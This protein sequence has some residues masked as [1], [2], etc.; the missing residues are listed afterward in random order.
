VPKTKR[1]QEAFCTADEENAV[2]E[3]WRHHHDLTRQV[4]DPPG[5]N[6][7]RGLSLGVKMG[8]K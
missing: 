2:S 1:D 4:L 3:G 8:R 5:K 6:L 7:R